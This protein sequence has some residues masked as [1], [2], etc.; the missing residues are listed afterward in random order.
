MFL[1]HKN[2]CMTRYIYFNI[3][4]SGG[5]GMSAGGVIG[6]VFFMIFLLLSVVLV[7][8]FVIRRRGQ[9]PAFL[10]AL[11]VNDGGFENPSYETTNPVTENVNGG[12]DLG[13][14]SLA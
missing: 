12:H 6:L 11:V 5:S 4:D 14:E 9:E 13:G 7:V 10:R 3:S 2:V 8:V 1:F